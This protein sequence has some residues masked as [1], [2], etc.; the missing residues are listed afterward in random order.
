VVRRAIAMA[1]GEQYSRVLIGLI[2]I[3]LMSR[4]LTPAEIG[5]SVIGM[6]ITSIALGLRE[7]AT[8][9][10]L[11]RRE[12]VTQDDIRTSFT[13]LFVLTSLITAVMFSFAPGI[14][15]FYGD[16]GLAHF[17]RIAAVAGLIEAVALPIT[18]LLRREMAFGTLAFINITATTVNTVAIVLLAL[19][20]FSYMSVAWGALVAAVS[21]A[22]LSFYFRPDL[23]SLRPTLSAWR[24]LVAFGGY[25]GASFVVNRT[26]EAL[27]QLVLGH[28]LPHSAVGIYNRA[29]VTAGIPERIILSSVLSVAFP[30]LAAEIR[31]GRSLKRPY[32]RTLSLITVLYWP[33]LVLLVLLAQ[34]VVLVLLGHQWLAVVPLL[35]VIALATLAWFPVALTSPVLLAAGAPQDRVLA[36][37]VGRSVAAVI[38]C[39]AA[40]FGVAYFG[41]MA[42][43]ASQL[44][45]LPFQMVVALWFVRRHVAFRWREV[46]AAL[47][48]S[49]VVTATSAVGPIGV[50]ALPE[51]SL[52]LS[53]SATLLAL[54]L[55]AVGWLAGV[56]ATRHP[57]AL[58][59]AQAA[60]VIGA[61]SLIRRFMRQRLIAGPRAGEVR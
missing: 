54:I 60:E 51:F 47:W 61:T 55:A 27:P 56:L 31:E 33:A 43:A 9:D 14:G 52:D 28:V 1:A 45:S 17:V 19:A 16:Q 49:A 38:L 10:F 20:G 46:P 8:S 7:F 58:E 5:V 11:I 15:A 4:L 37:L 6:G 26:Y 22:A 25:N 39:V 29:N 42:M 57:A 44:I 36:D 50:V 24:S 48:K 41:I 35:Q 18:G 12:R 2:S 30:A 32:L 34:P 13:I 3:A 23:V 40:F 21:G 59:L 53:I